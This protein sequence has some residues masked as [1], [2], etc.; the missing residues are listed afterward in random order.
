MGNLPIA[1]SIRLLCAVEEAAQPLQ[2][3]LETADH[4]MCTECPDVP[5][6]AAP[7]HSPKCT[8]LAMALC[9]HKVAPH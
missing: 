9:R 5:A 8:G 3:N 6:D 1:G 7:A 2:V 4:S